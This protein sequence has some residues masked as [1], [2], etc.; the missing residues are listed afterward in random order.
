MPAGPDPHTP[1]P[2]T[3][4]VPANAP[5]GDA[6]RALELLLAVQDGLRAW[7]SAKQGIERLLGDLALPLGYAA[8]ALWLP[9]GDALFAHAFWSAPGVDGAALE[10]LLR[11]LRVER[12]TGLPGRA[13]MRAEPVMVG[14]ETDDGTPGRPGALRASLGLP[15]LAGA[16]VLGVIELYSPAPPVLGARAMRVLGAVAHEL[17]GVFDRRRGELSLSPLTSREVEVLTLAAS[18]LP[19]GGIGERLEISRGTVKSHLEH[20]YSKLEVGNRTAAVARALRM[21]LIE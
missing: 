8:G 3:G 7:A 15:A 4:E 20:I 6:E 21:G 18:G 14:S 13:W 12:G 11:P 9:R 1:A 2:Q 17:G 5:L 19:V 16:E 10:A